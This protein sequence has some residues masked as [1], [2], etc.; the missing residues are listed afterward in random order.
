MTASWSVLTSRIEEVATEWRSARPERQSRRNLDPADF[1]RLAN[2]GFLHVA[3][4]EEQGGLWWSVAESTRPIGET[5]RALAAAD[6]SVALVAS[7]H[8]A[9]L[10][11]WLARPDP[12][13]PEWTEQREAAFASAASGRQ[14]GTI[15]SEP[16]SGGDILRTRTQARPGRR[17]LRTVARSHL[18]RERRQALRQR[19]GRD[20]LHDHDRGA[21]GRGC[22]DRVRARRARSPV[23]RLDGDA[24]DGGMGRDGDGCNAEPRHAARRLP[25]DPV[26]VGRTARGDP[27]RGRTTRLDAVHLRGP[28][29]SRRGDPDRQGATGAEGGRPASVRA[30]RMVP[31][32]TRTLAR[33]A[34]L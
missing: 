20:G 18:P 33:G 19:L 9:V 7:M 31:R 17:I 5:L 2:A 22:A 26:R 4:P 27:A 6:P 15:T 11:F 23:G 29:C 12:A 32:R 1:E 8:P 24:A 16:G 10:G 28:R 25:G 14:W 21:R 3:V 34:G 30:G 13:R